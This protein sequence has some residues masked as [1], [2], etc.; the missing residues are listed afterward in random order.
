MKHYI[1]AT[2][3]VR[4]FHLKEKIV[5]FAK[6]ATLVLVFHKNKNGLFFIS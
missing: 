1:F 4:F 5:L 6:R 2:C 3:L